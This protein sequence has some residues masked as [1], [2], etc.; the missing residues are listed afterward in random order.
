MN[1]SRDEYGVERFVNTIK[2][3]RFLKAGELGDKIIEDV[4]NFAGSTPAHDDITLI[5]IKIKEKK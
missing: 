5:I 2:T 3:N 4:R 1:E